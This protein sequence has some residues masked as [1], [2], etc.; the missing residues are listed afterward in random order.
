M[1]G[2]RGR[3]RIGDGAAGPQ[4]AE[5][6]TC[7]VDGNG[8]RWSTRGYSGTSLMLAARSFATFPKVSCDG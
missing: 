4:P 2:V 3:P 8:E 1:R 7:R 5:V 6:P